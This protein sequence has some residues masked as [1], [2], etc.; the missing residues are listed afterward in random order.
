MSQLTRAHS[1]STVFC[2]RTKCTSVDA[3]TISITITASV[4]GR[5]SVN[6]LL[7]DSCVGCAGVDRRRAGVAAATAHRTAG[8]ASSHA[9]TALGGDHLTAAAKKVFLGGSKDRSGRD[10][11]GEK[12][13]SRQDRSRDLVNVV[14][15]V[16]AH[17][18]SRSLDTTSDGRSRSKAC[19]RFQEKGSAQSDGQQSKHLDL[20]YK[21][22]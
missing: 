18:Q 15:W 17:A 20:E 1:K 9:S 7:N 5:G 13:G 21:R 11:I 3:S 2:W 22:W 16:V 8:R 19:S 12:V 6:G 4:D 14:V 10:D